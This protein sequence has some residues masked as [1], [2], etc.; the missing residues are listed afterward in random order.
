[1]SKREVEVTIQRKLCSIERGH[2]FIVEKFIIA[3]VTEIIN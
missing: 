2:I 3:L 1:M